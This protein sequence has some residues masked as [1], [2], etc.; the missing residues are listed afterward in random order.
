MLNT[1]GGDGVTVAATTMMVAIV[2]MGVTIVA[3]TMITV[4]KM[5]TRCDN[6]DDCGVIV[7][8]MSVVANG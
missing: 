5:L 2:V 3:M 1:N 6:G 7:E 4:A 8:T